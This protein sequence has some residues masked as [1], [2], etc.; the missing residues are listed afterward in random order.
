VLGETNLRLPFMVCAG[1]TFINFLF[2]VLVMPESMRPEN[3]RSIDWS[4]LNPVGALRAV[5]RY[6]AVASLVP[7]FVAAQLAQQSLQGVWV[8]YTTYRYGWGIGQ[9][10]ASLAVVGL[11][12]AFSQG[13]LVRPAVSRLGEMRTIVTALVIAGVGMA[14]FGL[15]SQGWMMYAVTALYFIGCGL[16]NPA[17]QG[18]MSRA[19]A[20]NE[21]GLLQ[22]AVTSM[23]TATAIVGPPMANGLFAFAISDQT[24]VRLPGA[25]F[26]LGCLLCLAALLWLV[27]LPH[28]TRPAEIAPA[29]AQVEMT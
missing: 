17:I 21:Q 18:L 24:P 29:S 9:V 25:P 23:I 2:G 27:R 6:R 10:G 26:F 3:R 7:V 11:L 19:V 5:W 16:F 8:L 12:F 13:A 22:G 14:L 1:L 15:A 28:H 20:A 4:H